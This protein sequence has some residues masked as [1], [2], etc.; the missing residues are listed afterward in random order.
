MEIFSEEK[1]RLSVEDTAVPGWTWNAFHRIIISEVSA[2]LLEAPNIFGV[3]VVS[4]VMNSVFDSGWFMKS[5]QD[6]L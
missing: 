3:I 1:V 6:S 4:S 2:G 5:L